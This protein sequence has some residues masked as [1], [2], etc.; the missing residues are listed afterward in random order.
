[1]N[2]VMVRFVGFFLS[3]TR[4]HYLLLICGWLLAV[5]SRVY[6]NG[7]SYGLDYSVFQP[8]G[9]NYTLRTF[10]FLGRDPL[11]SA[12]MI[13]SWYVLYGGSGNHFDPSSILPAN[14]PVWGLSEPRVLYPLLSMPFVALLGIS[15]MLVIPSLSLLMLVICVYKLSNIY[16]KPGLGFILGMSLLLSP[17]VLRWMVANI[18][19]SL[20]AGL[21]AIVCLI[22]ESKKGGKLTSLQLGFLII[23]TNATR[24]ATP[25]WLAIALSEFLCGRKK[26]AVLISVSALVASIPTFLVQPSSSIL[27]GEGD[28]NLIEKLLTMPLSFAKILFIEIAQLAVVDRLLLFMIAISFFLA[29]SNLRN[30]TNLRF[31]LVLL[32]VWAIGALNGSLGVN[33]RYQ[34]PVLPFACAVIVLNSKVLENRLLRGFANIKGRESR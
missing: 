15:G 33:F 16:L 9:V 12:S 3:A 25:I 1:V 19:D 4:I 11:T 8:D 26:R 2:N 10:M 22:L 6:L 27:P 24:F 21:F 14:N 28:L 5:S 23:L 17:T 34:L 7:I 31:L 32:S 30:D 13:E 18:T 29:I 20:F